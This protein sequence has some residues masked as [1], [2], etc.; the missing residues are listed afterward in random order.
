MKTVAFDGQMGASG[1]MMLGALIAM[2][3]D[4][5]ALEPV[6][7]AL[8][9]TFEW[10]RRERHG[11]EAIDVTVIANDAPAEGR[12]PHRSFD[13]VA[14]IVES[15]AVPAPAV[16]MANDAF[17]LL[18][19]AE[20]S[21]HGSTIEAIHFHEVGADDAIADVTGAAALLT[22]IDPDRI[23]TAPLTTGSGEVETS[24]GTYPVPVPAVVEIAARSDFT[25]R[26][27]PI[28]AEL[29]TPTGAA[30]LGSVADPVD[31]L[32]ALQLDAVGYGAG[33]R[34][35]PTRPNVLR[36]LVGRTTGS[37]GRE[38]ISLLETHI[39]D[40][41]PELLGYLQERLHDVG[42]RDVAV[43]PLTMKKSRPG[44]LIK[45]VVRPEDEARVA[46]TLAVETGSLGIRASSTT[47][48]WVA[49]RSI[50][51]VTITIEDE[52]YD[53]GVKIATDETD[54]IVDISSEYDDAASVANAT[55]LPLR[56]VMQRAEAAINGRIDR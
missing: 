55:G 42:A 15:M 50:E 17:H 54:T 44:H 45:V 12:G 33:D 8:D 11:I 20:A 52:P 19:Q 10:E 5:A 47:H 28:E 24:H 37:L 56:D 30:I 49:Q 22:D 2:D 14:D 34:S 43:V 36:G 16:A 4:P 35:F 27:G 1:D 53:I 13:E 48:R 21:V 18:A 3:A 7:A 51:T 6:E 46:R 23:V 9:V 26:T 29:L 32:P 31:Q 39:D 40:A 38:D 41:T 25:L